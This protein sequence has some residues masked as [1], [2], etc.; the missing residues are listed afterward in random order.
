[1]QET[2][3]TYDY[4]KELTWLRKRLHGDLLSRWLGGELSLTKAFY[5]AE[6]PIE[7]QLEAFRAIPKYK[8]PTLQMLKATMNELL[9]TPP[10]KRDAVWEAQKRMLGF[11]LGLQERF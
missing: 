2:G 3:C 9:S 11:V 4:V 1:V 8:R 10:E 6:F 7:E 5:L